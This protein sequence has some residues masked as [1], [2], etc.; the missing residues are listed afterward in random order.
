MDASILP[1]ALWTLAACVASFFLCAI[2]FG[3]IIARSHGVDVRKVGSGNIGTTNV[4]RSVG[5]SASALTLLLDAGK[6]ALCVVLA[7]MLI[8]GLAGVEAAAIE[9][10]GAQ[11]W[12]LSLV[13]LFC[14]LG[15]IFTPYLHFHGGKGIAVGFG[16]ALALHWPLALGIL[17]TF[18]VV[19]IPTR[20]VSAA[21]ISAAAMLTLLSIVF[22]FTRLAILPIALASTVVIWAHR[23]NIERL[24]RHEEKQFSFHSSKG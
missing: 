11:G 13:Y 6:G 16:G 1:L 10:T 14:V 18:I 12:V 4:A 9:P 20:Y 19:V 21:S 22:G 3:L 7:R 8:P 23:E 2:P 17:A 24:R 15:H 5:K